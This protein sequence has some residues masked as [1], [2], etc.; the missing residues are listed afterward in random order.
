MGLFGEGIETKLTG[1]N[2][3]LKTAYDYLVKIK[4]VTGEVSSGVSGIGFGGGGGG[5]VGSGGT[6]GVGTSGNSMMPGMTNMQ[7]FGRVTM[8]AISAMGGVGSAMLGGM[9]DTNRTI[10]YATQY[11]NASV[12]QRGSVNWHNMSRATFGAMQGG[13]T[14]VG[15]DARVAQYMSAQGIN[16]SGKQGSQWMGTV[17]GVANAAKY[18]NMD[19]MTATQAITGLKSG[20]MSATLM[21]NFGI[22]TSDWN[23]GKTLSQ[24]QIFGQL[25]QRLT[26]GQRQ[27]TEGEVM[28]SWQRGSLG[29]SLKSSGLDDTQQQMMVQYMLERARGNNM[30]LEDKGAMDKLLKETQA[31]KDLNPAQAGMDINTSDTKLMKAATDTYIEAQ[32]RAVVKIKATND[33]LETWIPT[34]G[35]LKAEFETIAGSQGAGG[36]L[37]SF[38]TA[39]EGVTAL[40]TGLISTGALSGLGNLLGG[41]GGKSGSGGAAPTGGATKRGVGSKGKPGLT[42]KTTPK[43]ATRTGGG[44]GAKAGVVGAVLGTVMTGVDAYNVAE[45]GGDVW[46]GDFWGQV[47]TNAAVGAGIGALSGAGVFSL[48]GALIGG[49]I[50]AGSTILGNI[51]GSGISNAQHPAS[52]TSDV[53]PGAGTRT[54]SGT[55]SKTLKFKWPVNGK[56]TDGFGNRGAV[57][58][59]SGF[60]N[61]QDIAA[62]EGTPI[63]ASEAGTVVEVSVQSLGGKFVKIK[64]SN[65]YTTGYFHMSS[66]KA[67]VGREVKQGETVGL[68]G[69]TGAATGPHVHFTVQDASGAFINPQSVVN[70]T[71]TATSSQGTEK[72]TSKASALAG[73]SPGGVSTD[74]IIDVRAK[75]KSASVAGLRV[76]TSSS[77]STSTKSNLMT[78]NSQPNGVATRETA[79]NRIRGMY[80]PGATRSKQGDPYVANDG[81]VNVHAGEAILTAEQADEWRNSRKGISTGGKGENNVTINLTIASASDTEARRFAQV[82]KG[83]LE[84]DQMLGRM[85]KN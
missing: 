27:A 24:G 70:G 38:A 76:G 77:Q 53:T 78:V 13:L 8:G 73:S 59:Q 10:N 71:V 68:V 9:P 65:G 31:N 46:G 72:D 26:A 49:A 6:G 58:G 12:Q 2:S 81:P 23:T 19:N 4:R 16:Y 57:A 33:I 43:P 66:Q 54:G 62:P 32:Q 11:W 60:H 80:L 48:P 50:G 21:R 63:G 3:Q 22:Q 28:A 40:L 17:T 35:S 47:G 30:D 64:H 82:V 84:D 79:Q 37:K 5:G 42:P 55:T 41:K 74:A 83:Y 44:A 7:K 61:G 56:F 20:S 29:A 25:A 39:I 85:G 75:N 69:M 45:S 18:L 36:V 15:N 67:V 34:L 14:E 52:N 1:I 51:I